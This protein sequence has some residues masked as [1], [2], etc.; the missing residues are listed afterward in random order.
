[1]SPASCLDPAKKVVQ[2]ADE[3]GEELDD[4]EPNIRV[5]TATVND[6]PSD[7][8]QGVPVIANRVPAG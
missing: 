1:M 3:R 4:Y 2:W 5:I 7:Q 6:Q 8:Q